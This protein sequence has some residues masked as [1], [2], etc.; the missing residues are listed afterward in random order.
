MEGLYF[1]GFTWALWIIST[2][3]FKKTSILRLPL[4]II[5]L[6]I[7]ILSPYNFQFGKYTISYVSVFMLL[8]IFLIVGTFKV[9]KLLYFFITTITI[10]VCYV[11]FLLFELFDP[12]WII[13]KRE[14]MLSFILAYLS[15]LLQKKVLGRI[16]IM[17]VGGV[18]GDILFSIILYP[19]S[20]PYDIG[21]LRFLDVCSLAVMIVFGWEGIKM[22]IS[23]IESH[24]SSLEKEKQ[25][26][27]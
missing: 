22:S 6:F 17:I 16:F 14:L 27:T 13:F 4:A 12:I 2:F 23:Y 26:T 3:L 9:R 15:V 18:Y 11:T 5:L 10:A 1:Y 20:F 24:L 25:K 21:S 7:L 8:L 19:F